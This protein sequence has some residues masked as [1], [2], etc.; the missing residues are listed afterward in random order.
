MAA[1]VWSKVGSSTVSLRSLYYGHTHTQTH[2]HM[3]EGV[4]SKV[5]SATVRTY[6]ERESLYARL[7]VPKLSCAVHAACGY[8]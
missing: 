7:H 5:G 8:H 3:A 1:C 4:W 2:K 6:A